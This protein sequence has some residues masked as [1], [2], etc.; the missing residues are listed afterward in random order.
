MATLKSQPKNMVFEGKIQVLDKFII[1]HK[2]ASSSLT[3]DIIVYGAQGNL[4]A[5]KKG[6]YVLLIGTVGDTAII[7]GDELAASTPKWYQAQA[8]STVTP[9][10]LPARIYAAGDLFYYDEAVVGVVSGGVADIR[11]VTPVSLNLV[12]DVD[13]AQPWTATVLKALFA[14]CQT[15]YYEISD[16]ENLRSINNALM[17]FNLNVDVHDGVTT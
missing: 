4:T 16:I 13:G 6:G 7:I 5:A 3:A 1:Y 12:S 9:T 14:P 2:N 17:T 15:I 8:D 11:E 10:D